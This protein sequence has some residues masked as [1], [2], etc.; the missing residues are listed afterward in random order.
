MLILFKLDFFF[1][2]FFTFLFYFNFKVFKT[3]SLLFSNSI[4]LLYLF[5]LS[6]DICFFFEKNGINYLDN[7][8]YLLFFKKHDFFFTEFKAGFESLILFY[9]F[10]YFVFMEMLIPTFF[11]KFKNKINIFDKALLNLV[12][13]EKEITNIVDLKFIFISILVIFSWVNFCFFFCFLIGIEFFN[14]F[15]VIFLMF[16]CIILISLMFILIDFGIFFLIFLKGLSNSYSIFL[17]FLYDFI[18][19]FIYFIRL[20]IQLIRIVLLFIVFFSFHEYFFSINYDFFFFYFDCTNIQNNYYVFIN[21]MI[22]AL[23][24]YSY[25]WF[26][27]IHFFFVTFG[28][29]TAFLAMI[30]WLFFFL[31]SFFFFENYEFFLKKNK[32]YRLLFLKKL[33]FF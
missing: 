7:N 31:Y 1:K 24:L 27:I 19:V 2:D 10:L 29:F 25:Y 28:Q 17:E 8:N 16:Y 18:N 6:K 14:V 23:I 33:N 11:T 13:V 5:L 32:I 30:F 22:D 3:Q 15:Y 12:E 20:I 9:C 26:E 21:K 4:N